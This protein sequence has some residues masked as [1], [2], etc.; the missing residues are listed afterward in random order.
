MSKDVQEKQNPVSKKVRRKA[1]R[2]P[3]LLMMVVA[4]GV[5]LGY[6]LW[7]NPQILYQLRDSL[8]APK[9]KEDVYQPQI[10]SLQ[11]QV[12]ALKMQ[13]AMVEKKA[14]NPDFSEME[15]RI[16]NIEHIS[17]NTIKSKAD[18]ETVL[19]LIGRMDTAEGRLND[20]AKVTDDGALILT[21][22]MLVK[23]AGERGGAFIYEAEVLSELAAGHHKIAA[24]VAKINE[25]AAKGVPSTD[26]LQREF[27]DI[28]LVKYPDVPVEEVFEG[29][30]WKDRIYHQLHK[31]VRIKKADEAKTV[32]QTEPSEEDR[33]W[34]IIRDFV[35]NG[36]IYRAIA[37]AKKPLNV[38]VAEDKDLAEW[39]KRAQT[40]QDFYD[41]IS[42]ISANALAVMKVKFLQNR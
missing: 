28:Y 16:D 33:A 11:D 2:R 24:E 18:V 15:K 27:A 34:G 8:F 4:A 42:R 5:V 41:S 25:I 38:K 1:F 36:D 10:N 30:N 17:V 7:E 35:A 21:A 32:V 26:E 12:S 37:I 3:L 22:A 31:V 14:E 9:N 39:L 20:L 40:Y 6:K 23:D 13:L 29:E 19:G